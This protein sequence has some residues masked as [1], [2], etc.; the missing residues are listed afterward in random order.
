LE[1]ILKINNLDKSFGGVHAVNHV[2][3]EVKKGEILGLIGPNGS[4]KSTCVNLISGVYTPDS[5]EIIFDGKNIVKMPV[6]NRADLGIGRTFQSP[7]PFS[8]LTV[9]ES[10]FTIA[11][12]HNRHMHDAREKTEQ[13]LE[14]TSLKNLSEIKS[15]KLP[16]EKRKWLD[17]ARILAINPKLIMMD[18]VM[19]GL[20]PSEMEESIKLVKK[21]NEEG[22][23]VI[24]IEHVMTA[25]MKLCHRVIVLNEGSLLSEGIPAEVMKE[26]AVIKAYLG[27]GYADDKN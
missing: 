13:I 12:V 2:S 27:G 25:V 26:E 4:G 9:Y 10:V 22:I 5:G 18:E 14:L 20:N 24:F 17:L 6:P 23:T 1:T 16:I 19:A 7:K 8:N 21:I 3:F 15:G 11:L